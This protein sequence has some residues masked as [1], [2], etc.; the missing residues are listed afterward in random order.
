LR[1]GFS[2]Y[3]FLGGA[4]ILLFS[5]L[6]CFSL[7]AEQADRPSDLQFHRWTKQLSSKDWILQA[8]AM[9]G[10]G[11]WKVESAVPEIS[12]ILRDGGSPWVRGRAMVTL[13]QIKGRE[14][15]DFANQ[16]SMDE[17]PLLRMAALETFELVGE[18][19]ASPVVKK[20]LQDSDVRVQAMA[21]ALYASQFP[22]EA[23]PVVD[24]LTISNQT[25]ISKNL[26]R[27]LAHI[28]SDASLKRL[29]NIFE[30]ADVDGQQR[31]DLIE[32][33]SVADDRAIPFLARVTAHY[34]SQTREFR[35][36]QDILS[37][38]GKETV[39]KTFQAMLVDEST[40]L[41]ENLASLVAAVQPTP[42]LGDLLA[43]SWIL[44]KD[45]PQEAARSGMVALS[46]IAPAR[47]KSFFSHYLESEDPETRA[48]AVRCRS[49]GSVADLFE[50]Y[51]R[52]VQDEDFRVVQAT[53]QSLQRVPFQFRPTG[54][55]LN[56]LTQPL[57][58]PNK[59]VLHS[60]I[61]LLGHRGV[62]EEFEPS[63]E[64]L[65]PLL[66]L[67]DTETREVAADAL[68]RLGGYER[69]GEVAKA[70]GYIGNWKIVGPFLNDRS[71]KGF[72]T[73]YK[74][75]ED[76]NAEK[77]EA[78]YRWDFGGGNGN[79]TLELTW[80]DAVPQDVTGAIHVAAQMP[81]PIKYAVA[82][83]KSVIES[84]S[85]RTVRAVFKLNSRMAQKLWLNGEVA[86]DTVQ[87]PSVHHHSESTVVVRKLSLKK[88]KNLIF[89]K[90]STFEGPWWLTLRLLHEKEKKMAPG[91][92][93]VFPG[94]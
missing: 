88:G 49:L 69:F 26:L 61:K 66:A 13:G 58:S 80:G 93:Q 21:A 86:I 53:L 40:L 52:H 67:E 15:L 9:Q 12:R 44:R 85:D 1:L 71:N 20:L 43:G 19:N 38:L 78:E 34:D 62:P 41:F 17:S 54:G 2:I 8:E 16:A 81:V 7:F 60:A 11:R 75:E 56:Y 25:S 84:D 83:A 24:R 3:W 48:L 70:Q 57:R 37:S 6:S 90:T 29:E 35:V 74:P 64:I 91:L 23:W 10:L 5:V 92:T 76:L 28:S 73:I 79:R 89:V 82:Y 36:G 33:M 27:A 30:A 46:R 31:R 50:I 47:Y 68:S 72:E 18:N 4:W 51:R 45:L 77:Y 42:Q 39:S 22:E 32:A 94:S 65:K 63:L 59:E 87:S 55:L 14:M